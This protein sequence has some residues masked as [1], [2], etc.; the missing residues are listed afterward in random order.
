MVEI[1]AVDRTDIIEAQLL[2]QHAAGPEI[3]RIF[4]G[5]ARAALPILGQALGELLDEIADAR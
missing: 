4:L 1:M 2:E 3:A 5:A